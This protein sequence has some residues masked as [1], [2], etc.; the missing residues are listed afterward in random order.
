MALILVL[1]ACDRGAGTA[2]GADCRAAVATLVE[3]VAPH[4]PASAAVMPHLIAQ[5][6][7]ES[8][9]APARTC[10]AQATTRHALRECWHERLTGVQLDHLKQTAAPLNTAHAEGL[11][12]MT[13]F[14]DKMC[15]CTTAS[16]VDG[17]RKQWND[18]G[19]TTE[20][21]ILG[22]PTDSAE[23]NAQTSR[24]MTELGECEQKAYQR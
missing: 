3:T 4:H 24:L 5:C 20:P 9:S 14:R 16:C 1:E 11:A 18:A 21:W 12:N 6:D 13:S 22:W 23:A 8:W 15:A 19:R 10:M 17:V 2:R 7:A